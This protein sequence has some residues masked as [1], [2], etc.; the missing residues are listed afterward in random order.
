MLIIV[1]ALGLGAFQSSAAASQSQIKIMRAQFGMNEFWDMAQA[2]AGSSESAFLP[3]H[4]VFG[5]ANGYT[6][7]DGHPLA[8]DTSTGIVA[9]PGSTGHE[10][11]FYGKDAFHH[12]H[13]WAYV[14]RNGVVAK[15]TYSYRDANG[16][17]VGLASSP[18]W[19]LP[20]SSFKSYYLYASQVSSV[21]SF[22]QSGVTASGSTL[23]DVLTA[24]PFPEV[25]MGNRLVAYDIVTVPGNAHGWQHVEL[26]GGVGGGSLSPAVGF[27]PRPAS[28]FN[29]TPASITLGY[30]GAN[31]LPA[32]GSFT[33]TVTDYHRD[34]QLGTCGV[35][36]VARTSQQVSQAG[37]TAG[38][39]VDSGAV[40]TCA[41]TVSTVG[42]SQSATVQISVEGALSVAPSFL[43]F[44]SA[45][46]PSQA[47][48]L[49][50]PGYGGAFSVLANGCSGYA[51]L[52][53]GG[54][55]PG[56]IGIAVQPEAA[57]RALPNSICQ[58]V[59]GD[60][61]GSQGTLTV[62]VDPPAPTPSPSPT[63]TICNQA[64]PCLFMRYAVGDGA[65][66]ENADCQVGANQDC[67]GSYAYTVVD[68][69][70][71]SVDV[72]A[73][74]NDAIA[75]SD[76]NGTLYG[77]GSSPPTA[78]VPGESVCQSKL[79]QTATDQGR[80]GNDNGQG[81]GTPFWFQFLLDSGSPY[82]LGVS[83]NGYVSQDAAGWSDGANQITEA[84]C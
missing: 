18:T 81:A 67:H 51:Q 80:N 32:S 38:Y 43:R 26:L 31:G 7:G 9:A 13:F 61:Y 59:F 40:G 25:F 10:L 35:A 62:E 15:Y 64:S 16:L 20:A 42:G 21:N 37:E 19:S 36:T 34:L 79:W 27:T 29:V 58:I 22:V 76:A 63:P 75:K 2:D 41:Q 14:F 6:F 47:S 49:A 52:T 60:I 74:A 11:D 33:A 5:Q 53:G 66:Y 3:S 57:T 24:A 17:A 56:P 55:G 1:T 78:G 39:N 65:S 69:T 12:P 77:P 68:G 71:R 46:A 70:G 83:L 8:A 4:D 84:S 73:L 28:G 50:E 54:N 30:Q 45:S 48:S 72:I 23:R 44:S 82:S